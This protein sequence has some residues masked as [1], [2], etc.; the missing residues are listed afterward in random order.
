MSQCI[1]SL[2]YPGTLFENRTAARA[3]SPYDDYCFLST[4]KQN[5]R[6][7]GIKKKK[8][9]CDSEDQNNGVLSDAFYD[10]KTRDKH[11]R[12]QSTSRFR[13]LEIF[14]GR[15][16]NVPNISVP[17]R[18]LWETRT[19]CLKNSIGKSVGNTD[20]HTQTYQRQLHTTNDWKR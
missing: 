13:I 15:T 5:A 7:P 19:Y 20:L 4:R 2:D 9:T 8:N 10:N 1:F 14:K 17:P 3:R 6:L 18:R 16:N 12:G 11:S